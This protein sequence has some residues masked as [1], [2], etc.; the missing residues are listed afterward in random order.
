MSKPGR[1]GSRSAVSK[2]APRKRR[3]IVKRI[4]GAPPA[5]LSAA[6]V[7]SAHP[8]GDQAFSD[9]DQ[10]ASA[11][12]QISADSDQRSS[13][14]DQA[15]ADRDHEASTNLTATEE[16]AYDASRDD[17]EAGS[18]DRLAS[19][20]DRSNTTRERE[21][22]GLFRA[23]LDAGPNGVIAT[24]AD[25]TIMYANEDVEHMFG[26]PDGA[27]IGQPVE[28]LMPSGL[29]A[30]H[31]KLRKGFIEVP[32]ARPMG[33][34]PDR[35]GRR[36]DRTEFPID[37]SL[38]PIETSDGLR[39]FATVV[40]ITARKA[41]ES[42]RLHTQ[43]LESIG[44]LAAG[45]AHDFNNMLFAIQGYAT[46]LTQDLA[47]EGRANLDLDDS[48][49]NVQSIS[50]AAERAANLTAQLLAFSRRQV[51]SPAVI[52]INGAVTTIEPL[53]R[54]LV[55]REIRLNLALDG[56]PGLIEADPGWIDQ[57]VMNLVVNAR[58]AMPDGGT[59]VIETGRLHVKAPELIDDVLVQ[60]G[61][62]VFLAVT[63]SGVG[64]ESDAREHIF[65]P[66]FTTKEFGKGTGLGLATTHGI[67]SQAGGYILVASEPG[68]GATLKLLFPRVDAVALGRVR[69]AQRR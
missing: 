51:V 34:G 64:I 31:V 9:A 69:A 55:G 45:I 19:Q 3:A 35:I 60:R 57:I 49:V 41:E 5:S 65:E 36:L 39:V 10:T 61:S 47:P 54:Q 32:V 53:I 62:Y 43:K 59:V 46:L 12:D 68:H 23:V 27:L 37:V 2:E 6:D 67:V 30:N 22:T 18:E 20:V 8:G 63:D 58:D 14:R 48:L 11:A 7:D 25:G 24:D 29:S 16:H 66:Y 44:R 15:A 33:I 56:S 17:R 1:S 26:Y 50:L 42:R 52:D 40:D 21:I 28:V 38:T 13:D 4:A